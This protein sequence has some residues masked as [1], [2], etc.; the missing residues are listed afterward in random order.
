MTEATPGRI[1]HYTLS[2]L[3]A[4]RINA[5]RDADP[6]TGNRVREGDVVPAIIVR[7]WPDGING[8]AFLDGGDTYW[9]TSR[10]QG[11][12]PG[13]WAWPARTDGGAR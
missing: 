2:A 13:T 8:Q 6:S 12:G 7:V 4:E 10:P 5:R 3:D 11:I 9:L 1:V